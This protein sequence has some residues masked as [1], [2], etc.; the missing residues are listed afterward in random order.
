VPEDNSDEFDECSECSDDVMMEVPADRETDEEDED[1]GLLKELE[2]F[3][4]A[5]LRL[6][7]DKVW[8]ITKPSITITKH[9]HKKRMR[10]RRLSSWFHHGMPRHHMR[11]STHHQ[12][13]MKH[14]ADTATTAGALMGAMVDSHHMAVESHHK[15][16]EK[17]VADTATTALTH[18]AISEEG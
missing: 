4:P 13:A 8:R 18:D 15:A 7:S 2:E 10:G 1:E 14:V 6:S 11:H 17:H 16:V 3:N 5:G 12:A 9:R